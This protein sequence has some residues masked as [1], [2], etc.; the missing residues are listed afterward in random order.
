MLNL[1]IK[2]VIAALVALTGVAI[3]VQRC[4]DM[5]SDD[6]FT[7]KP[8][9]SPDQKYKAILFSENGGGAISPYCFDYV[10]VAPASLE[11][12]KANKRAFHVYEGSCH[13]LGFLERKDKPPVLES[14][15]LI[16]WVSSSELEI[17]FD[18]TQ[19]SQGINKFLFVSQANE[20][21][22]RVTERRFRQ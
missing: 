8:L 16:K 19:A 2:R 9:Y 21:H 11:T 5:S 4:E 1:A 7:G 3:I 15:P 20:G 10:S 17:T 6:L 14:A 13:S 12:A 22:I 18:R